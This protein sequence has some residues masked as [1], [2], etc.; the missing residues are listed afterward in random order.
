MTNNSLPTVSVI[1]AAYNREKYIGYA[2][3]SIL[4]QTLIDFELIIIDDKSSDRTKMI[5]NSFADSRIYLISNKENIG[6]AKSRNLGISVSKGKYIAVLDS[7]DWSYPSRLQKQVDF[8]NKHP[9]FGMIGS[10]TETIDSTN[11]ISAGMIWSFTA[12]STEIPS[13]LL[14]SDYFAHSAVM[15]RKNALPEVPYMTDTTPAEDYHLWTRIDSK[16]KMWN[17]Q[18][19]LTQI[20]EHGEN[21]SKTHRQNYS[22]AMQTIYSHQLSK[23][24][25]SYSKEELI[26]HYKF[27]SGQLPFSIKNGDELSKWFNKLIIANNDAGTF[28]KFF[29]LKAL[30]G[31][32]YLYCINDGKTW[33]LPQSVFWK[34]DLWKLPGLNLLSKIRFINNVVIHTIRTRLSNHNNVSSNHI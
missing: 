28:N 12:T 17:L 16:Y 8:L 18:E 27:C 34:S 2:I 30:L 23:L 10:Y 7:D 3:K 32:W 19:I 26:F 11:N 21:L 25:F 24:R 14:F 31:R 4:D 15:I 13:I 5:I 9:D 20:R 33:W 1:M 22:T 29:F 6:A